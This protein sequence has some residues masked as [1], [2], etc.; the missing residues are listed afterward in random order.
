MIRFRRSNVFDKNGYPYGLWK[1][2][3]D[4]DIFNPQW[5]FILEF[6]NENQFFEYLKDI[7]SNVSIE[8]GFVYGNNSIVGMIVDKRNERV[9]SDLFDIFIKRKKSDK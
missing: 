8:N 7:V 3:D 4:F 6:E 1:L 9:G 5:P 2:C